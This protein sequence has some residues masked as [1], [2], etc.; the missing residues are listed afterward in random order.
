MK[1][2]ME[3]LA[4]LVK[5]NMEESS[6][7]YGTAPLPEVD[8]LG[9]DYYIKAKIPEA[10]IKVFASAPAYLLEQTDAREILVPKQLQDG[11][12]EV[13][14]PDD[15]LKMT[16]FRMQGWKRA[17]TRFID[18]G[19]PAAELQ[20]N[21]YSRGGVSK[22]VALITNN[23]SGSRVLRYYSLPPEVRIHKI[24][25]ALYVK[26][27]DFSEPLEINELLLPSVTYSAAAMVY[28]I[29]GEIERAAIMERRVVV[30]KDYK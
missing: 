30:G 22:P 26:F 12:G 7:A 9:I 6:Q 16:L 23:G 11:S 25:E 21:I 20:N 19:H 17:V 29:T 4:G 3:T 24:E 10:V 1:Y 28:E 13:V 8:A 18:E 27:P 5:T 2:S 15:M 14:L